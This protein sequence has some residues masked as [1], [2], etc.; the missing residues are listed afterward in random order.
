MTLNLNPVIFNEFL[1]NVS[2]KQIEFE[3]RIGKFVFNPELKKKVFESSVEIP[4]FYRLLNLN[5]M[6]KLCLLSS[7]FDQTQILFNLRHK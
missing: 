3:I 2:N 5:F 6:S 7:Y 4:F 1:R